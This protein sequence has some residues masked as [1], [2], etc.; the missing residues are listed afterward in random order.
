MMSHTVCNLP[1]CLL[2]FSLSWPPISS[3]TFEAS[4]RILDLLVSSE[5]SPLLTL[6][7]AQHHSPPALTCYFMTWAGMQ[8]GRAPHP[9]GDPYV[10]HLVKSRCSINTYGI[11]GKKK[12]KK[13]FMFRQKGTV[14]NESSKSNNTCSLFLSIIVN[15]L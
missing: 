6:W 15:Y 5:K 12:N 3:S 13:K 4:S 10:R 7:C 8:G 2:Y 1:S 14:L 11:N 9:L